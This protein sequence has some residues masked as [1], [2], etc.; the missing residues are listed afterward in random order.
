MSG[1]LRND[2]KTPGGKY[3]VQRRDGSIPEWPYLVLGGKDPAA[4]AGLLAYAAK[5]EELGYDP[6]YVE[7]IRK[8]AD[9][10][11]AYRAESGPGNPTEGSQCRDNPEIVT[12]MI[13][14]CSV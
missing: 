13:D 3:L 12:R 14:G 5:A 10:F 1:L 2:E 4:V 11:E 7:D 6:V 8:L 9:R